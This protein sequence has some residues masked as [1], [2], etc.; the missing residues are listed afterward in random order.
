MGTK[1]TL[2]LNST[3]VYCAILIPAG[4]LEMTISAGTQQEDTEIFVLEG[5]K[6]V[7]IEV[8]Q[9][10]SGFEDKPKFNPVKVNDLHATVERLLSEAGIKV[11][12]DPSD[13]PEI[14]HVVVT[15]NVWKGKLSIDFIVQVKAELYQQAALVRDPGVQILT[16]TWPLGEKALEAEMP[17]V[18][19]RGEIARKVEEQVESQVK[20]LIDDYLKANPLPEP[21]PDISGMMTGTIRYIRHEGGC[22]NIFAD[23]G[24]QYHPVN[25][26]HQYRQ[27]GL[28]IA[29]RAV[30]SDL[31]GIPYGGVWI[32]LT[33]I[34]KL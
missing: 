19:T 13:D 8:V 34:V 11:V 12:D 14:G 20:M 26:P 2:L 25:L 31:A 27:H 21:R 16:P 4:L 29:F 5:L 18:V 32:E 3:V 30:R 17:V 1:R 33:R 28:R 6:G 7:S 9:P 15:I 22:Y 10:V 24:V 23:N